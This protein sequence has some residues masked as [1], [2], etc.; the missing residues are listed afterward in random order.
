[1]RRL[2]Q[3]G[4]ETPLITEGFGQPLG[5]P[6]H[7]A[8]GGH[9]LTEYQHAVVGGHR[10]VQGAVDRPTMVIAC[11]GCGMGST[12]SGGSA[13]WVTARPPRQ[14]SPQLATLRLQPGRRS[15]RRRW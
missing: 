5:H 11:G 12:V 10:V 4:V 14:F 8:L 15:R 1:M 13:I 3:W 2:G 6:E 7:T 9:V